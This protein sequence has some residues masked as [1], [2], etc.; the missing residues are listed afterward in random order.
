MRTD[1]RPN[2]S[3]FSVQ[4]QY[5]A[6][7]LSAVLSVLVIISI[8]VNDGEAKG[9]EYKVS[10]RGSRQSVDRQ[11]IAARQAGLKRFKTG[12]SVKKHVQKGHLKRVNETRY[13]QLANVSYPYVRPKL[14]ALLK[15]LSRLYYQYCKVPLVVTSLTRPINEQPKNAS[16]RSVHPAGIA[17]DLRVPYGHCKTWLRKTLLSWEEQ[18]LIEATREKHP[19]HFHIVAIPNQLNEEI[20]SSLGTRKSKRVTHSKRATHSKRSTHSKRVY[21]VRPGDS[22][23]KLSQR[24][25][26]SIKAIMKLNRIRSTNLY[27]NQILKVP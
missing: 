19:P 13:L 23:W 17:A 15:R 10:L 14:N 2:M 9:K 18:G 20:I 24:W 27:E 4:K 21:R 7:V 12:R 1:S 11:V 3:P 25:K 5:F 8:G 26:V 16:H 22:L 6:L